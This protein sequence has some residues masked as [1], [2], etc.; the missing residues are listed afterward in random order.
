MPDPD[1]AAGRLRVARAGYRRLA[2]V[3]R[4]DR[5]HIFFVLRERPVPGRLCTTIRITVRPATAASHIHR[6]FVRDFCIC[7]PFVHVPPLG[8]FA[9][10]GAVLSRWCQ[11][12][13]FISRLFART[14]FPAIRPHR[15]TAHGR[16]AGDI[17]WSGAFPDCPRRVIQPFLVCP[18]NVSTQVIH[19][20]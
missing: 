14:G 15:L 6:F 20:Y 2:R 19:D 4:P 16:T 12:P 9:W 1:S 5:G 3:R 18:P 7:S 17:G 11:R 13:L 8:R 10:I